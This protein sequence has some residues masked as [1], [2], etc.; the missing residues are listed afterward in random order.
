VK[1]A[2]MLTDMKTGQLYPA[3]DW[4]PGS[5]DSA[6]STQE[7]LA[8]IQHHARMIA[9]LEANGL[10]DRKQLTDSAIRIVELLNSIPKG[11]LSEHDS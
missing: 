6:M 1:Q 10:P 7:K 9:S 5:I 4:P 3:G 2:I 11:Q 8:L